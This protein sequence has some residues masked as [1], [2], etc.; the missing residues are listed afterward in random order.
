[1]RVIVG[2][3]RGLVAL[4]R[5]DRRE[6]CEA[7]KAIV[8]VKQVPDVRASPVGVHA[9]GTIDRRNAATITNPADLHAVEAALHVADEVIALSMGPLKA[10]EAL[11]EAVSMGA[12]RGVLLCDRILAGSDTW[13]TANALAAAIGELGGAD[14][15]VGGMTAL[16]GETGLRG[17]TPRPGGG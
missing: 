7:V 15:I 13:A 8:L 16:D 9:D 10:E 17:R 6:D 14:I 4:A 3:P 5:S 11:R 1:M 12:D 2:G